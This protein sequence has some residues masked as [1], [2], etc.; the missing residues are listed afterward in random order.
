MAKWYKALDTFNAD[1]KDGG[2]LTVEK[3][4]P[5][6]EGH[7]VVKLDKGRGVLF[8]PLEDDAPEVTEKPAKAAASRPA[9]GKA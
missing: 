6:P 8:S 9:P 3:G 7:E 5:W 2:Q 4:S 1:L